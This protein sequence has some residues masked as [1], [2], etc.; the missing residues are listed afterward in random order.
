MKYTIINTRYINTI[1]SDPESVKP[2]CSCWLDGH[3]SRSKT[4]NTDS[5]CS[6][7]LWLY[8]L[9]IYTISR[10]HYYL[11]FRGGILHVCGTIFKIIKKFLTLHFQI[12]IISYRLMQKHCI[13]CFFGYRLTYINSRDIYLIPLLY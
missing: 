3:S 7:T 11:H 10:N 2:F 13:F 1:I 6:N 8:L 4:V 5:Q 12:L 9:H